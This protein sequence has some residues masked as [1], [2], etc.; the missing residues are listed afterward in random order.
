MSGISLLVGLMSGLYPA[1]FMSGKPA[2]DLFRGNLYRT[3]NDR[4][5]IRKVLIVFQF[6]IAVLFI[7]LTLNF[8]LQ[9]RYTLHKDIGF[10]RK[11][12]LYTTISVT[13][14]DADWELLRS[15]ILRHDGVENA[16]MSRFFP[17]ITFGGHMTTWE[18]S[19]PGEVIFARD[20]RVSYDYVQTL[21]MHISQGRDFSRNLPSERGT[22]CIINESAARAFSW[23]NPIG[24]KI[25]ERFQVIGVVR[26][27][28]NNDMYNKIEPFFMVLNPDTTMKGV[29]SLA[30][31]VDPEKRLQATERIQSELEEYFPLDPFELREYEASFNNEKIISIY[32]TIQNLV[33]FFTCLNM[34]IAIFGLLGLVSFTIQRRTKEIGIRKI[35]GS[36]GLNIFTRLSMQYI[37]LLAFA[38]CFAWTAAFIVFLKTPGTYKF[39][40]QLWPYLVATF[41]VMAIIFLSASFH[42]IRAANANPVD[43]LRYE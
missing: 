42:M 33:L 25:D 4:S 36:S 30:F 19:P 14:E 23:D 12:L 5:V 17:L 21:G 39:D 22:A 1:V 8:Y 13:R 32:R 10:D 18:G 11:D 28:H 6:S 16:S 24:K 2:L 41:L 26:D 43:A 34:L 7:I 20:N 29:W 27:F 40:F 9:L 35:H 15:R 38:S 37:V 31:R 3:S